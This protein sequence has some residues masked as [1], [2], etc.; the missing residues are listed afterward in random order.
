MKE[1]TDNYVFMIKHKNKKKQKRKKK[2]KKTHAPLKLVVHG[3]SDFREVSGV[4]LAGTS[5]YTAV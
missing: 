4:Y 2:K 3:S 5:V 1:L